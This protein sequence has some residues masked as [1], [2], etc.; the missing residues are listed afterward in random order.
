MRL[1]RRRGGM[2]FDFGFFL[3]SL[4]WEMKRYVCFSSVHGFRKGVSMI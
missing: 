1:G 3:L 4:V 2:S